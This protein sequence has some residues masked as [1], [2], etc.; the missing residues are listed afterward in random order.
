LAIARSMLA[1]IVGGVSA[2]LG[3]GPA[4]AGWTRHAAELACQH[5]R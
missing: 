4:A 2:A 5:G 1:T 3:L